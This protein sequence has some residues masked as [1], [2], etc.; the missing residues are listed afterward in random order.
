MVA[1]T[2]YHNLIESYIEVQSCLLLKEV[3]T[4]HTSPSWQ[5]IPSP[6]H[7]LAYIILIHSPGHL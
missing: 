2:T 3:H 4:L 6:I 5:Y 1:I 7:L